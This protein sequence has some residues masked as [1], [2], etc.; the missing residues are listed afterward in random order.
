MSYSSYMSYSSH[1]SYFDNQP[2][3]ETSRFSRLFSS[4]RS[5]SRGLLPCA[6]PTMPAFSSWSI[7][8]PARLYPIEKR[9]CIIEVE[10]CWVITI[11]WAAFSNNG[12][13]A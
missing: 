3:R 1:M 7:K 8:R 10:P 5:T 4:A 6:A 11:A 12:S 13:R 2:L 9:R